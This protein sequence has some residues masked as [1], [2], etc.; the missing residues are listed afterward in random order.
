VVL[1]VAWPRGRLSSPLLICG[2]AMGAEAWMRARRFLAHVARLE[3]RPDDV[4]ERPNKVIKGL[5]YVFA[6]VSTRSSFTAANS[7]KLWRGS[8]DAVCMGAF[9]AN[10]RWPGAQ[11]GRR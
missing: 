11:H 5:V 9:I 8:T 10:T 4:L 7:M 3:H 1:V 2:A 6:P